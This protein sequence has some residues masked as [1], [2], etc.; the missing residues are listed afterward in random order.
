MLNAAEIGPGRIPHD[1]HTQYTLTLHRNDGDGTP[2]MTWGWRHNHTPPAC[3]QVDLAHRLDRGGTAESQARPIPPPTFHDQSRIPTAAGG[4]RGQ[5]CTTHSLHSHTATH[6]HTS[7]AASPPTP[8]ALGGNHN[9]QQAADWGTRPRR[10]LALQASSPNN[11]SAPQPVM[12]RPP[13]AGSRQ[14]TNTRKSNI[15]LYVLRRATVHTAHIGGECLSLGSTLWVGDGVLDAR[16]GRSVTVV[17]PN[18]DP[19]CAARLSNFST[20]SG[21]PCPSVSSSRA[22]GILHPQYLLA[23]RR[24]GGRSTDDGLG[25]NGSTPSRAT[26]W[27]AEPP[28]KPSVWAMVSTSSAV[29]SRPRYGAIPP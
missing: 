1:F 20:A 17:N 21:F 15:G 25:A 6:H 19:L 13:D 11:N 16:D 28:P 7:T 5:R 22:V 14:V 9:M 29:P 3:C 27:R 26:I 2:R 10:P 4:A 24:G 8:S 18:D 23:C 12:A